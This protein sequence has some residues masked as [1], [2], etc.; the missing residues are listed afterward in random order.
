[1]RPNATA[2][3]AISRIAGIHDFPGTIVRIIC[4]PVI[5]KDIDSAA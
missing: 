3:P 5:L 1:M 2:P 4:L